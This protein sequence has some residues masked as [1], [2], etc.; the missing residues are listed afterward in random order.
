[1][2]GRLDAEGFMVFWLRFNRIVGAFVL[3]ADDEARQHIPTWI[4]ERRAFSTDTLANTTLD[5]QVLQRI[6]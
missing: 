3:N 6:R 1:M 2:R 5:F 4:R